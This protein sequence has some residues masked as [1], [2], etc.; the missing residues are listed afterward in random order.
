LHNIDH[1]AVAIEYVEQL[2][3]LLVPDEEMSRVTATDHVFVLEA[4]EVDVL[5]RLDIAVALVPARVGH[6][7][8]IRFDVLTPTAS[9][10]HG[11][12]YPSSSAGIVVILVVILVSFLVFFVSFS[13]IILHVARKHVM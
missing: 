4:E 3:C 2:R 8:N 1:F 7:G 5:D 11:T 10:E 9:V 12:V 13:V 6:A